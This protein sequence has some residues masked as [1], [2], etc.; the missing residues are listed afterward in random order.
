MEV[1]S[2]D[3]CA[4]I[5][6]VRRDMER[7]VE[8]RRE[9]LEEQQRMVLALEHM[10]QLA[11]ENESLREQLNDEKQQRAELEMKMAEMSKLSA[12]VAKKASQDD[13]QKALRIF[14][15][16]SKRKTQTKREAAKT[17]ITEMLTTAKLDLPD[18]I[19]DLLEHLDDVQTEVGTTVN[20]QP[21][22]INVQQANTVRK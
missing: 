5:A 3:F 10:E 4:W 8:R 2:N 9:A 16:T 17:V 18:D 21:G 1:L 22:G 6:D 20:V 13:M 11:R 12:G 19:M 7:D 14:L 15:N